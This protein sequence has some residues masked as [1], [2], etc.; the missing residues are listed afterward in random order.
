MMVPVQPGGSKWRLHR[1]YLSANFLWCLEA[2]VQ[3]ATITPALSLGVN[4]TLTDRFDP[5]KA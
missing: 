4:L 1:L 3:Y 2:E 5:Q